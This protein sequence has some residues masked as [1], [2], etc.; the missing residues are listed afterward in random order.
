MGMLTYRLINT[1]H[2]YLAMKSDTYK[3]VVDSLVYIETICVLTLLSV[4]V[5]ASYI[6]KKIKGD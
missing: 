4:V 1:W 5:Y 6:H 2:Q 3:K